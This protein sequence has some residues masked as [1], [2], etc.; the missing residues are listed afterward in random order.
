MIVCTQPMVQKGLLQMA[1]LYAAPRLHLSAAG[2]QQTCQSGCDRGAPSLSAAGPP[3]RVPHPP[4]Q[5]GRGGGRREGREGIL[6]K[7]EQ[8]RG[9]GGRRGME[10]E[11]E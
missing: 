1:N 2:A 7:T 8:E 4:M 5:G 10:E 6:M 11:M 9:G 3:A